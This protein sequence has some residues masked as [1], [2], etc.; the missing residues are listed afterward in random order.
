V[1]MI[2]EAQ[3]EIIKVVGVT[4]QACQEQEYITAS[5]PIKIME[6]NSVY[7]YKTTLMRGLVH[8]SPL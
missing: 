2:R 8:L 5:T 3:G 1:E 6:L 7:V 4:P